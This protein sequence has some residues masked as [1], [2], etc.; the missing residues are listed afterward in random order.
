MLNM[1]VLIVRG[2]RRW[3]ICLLLTLQ[4]NHVLKINNFRHFD[5]SVGND[6][7]ILPF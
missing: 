2:L 3:Y 1:I 7:V 4:I 6:L 5:A